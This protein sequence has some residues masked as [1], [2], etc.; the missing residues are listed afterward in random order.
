MAEGESAMTEPR[1]GELWA[2]Y[3][4]RWEEEALLSIKQTASV[5]KRLVDLRA[6][7]R[8]KRIARLVC[9]NGKTVGDADVVVSDKDPNWYKGPKAVL[10]DGLVQVRRQ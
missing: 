3:L 1:K 10:Q 5:R 4:D 8:A 7:M 6:E 2:D 9:V